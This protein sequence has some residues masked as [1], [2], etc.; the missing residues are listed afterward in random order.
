[1]T[2]TGRARFIA[3]HTSSGIITTIVITITI[4]TTRPRPDIMARIVSRIII[5][6]STTKSHTT[7]SARTAFAAPAGVS[8][9]PVR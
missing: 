8:F 3:K 2:I 6:A 1:M 5:Q 9:A 4:A 7:V